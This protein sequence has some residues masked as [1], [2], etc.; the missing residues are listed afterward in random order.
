M[1]IESLGLRE[2]KRLAT[3]HAIQLA[4]LT[5]VEESGLEKVTVEQIS[6]RA[7]VSPRT[8]FN[9]FPTK[10]A[11]LVGDPPGLPGEAE[12]AAFV[13]AGAE[14]SI[15][16][17]LGRLV[18]RSAA[19]TEEKDIVN[20]RRRL[21]STYPHL[22]AMRMVALHELED[23]LTEVVARRLTEDDPD[24]A[25]DAAAL[26]SKARLIALVA[27]GTMRHAW[28][29]WAAAGGGVALARHVRDSFGELETLFAA[30]AAQ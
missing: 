25:G 20:L 13:H 24:L 1:S 30:P 22:F 9:Y 3:R 7:D 17:G 15:L 21:L 5:L 14:E 19:T 18:A 8:F 2:R 16:T 27:L 23:Q 10:E 4:C 26:R 11:A 28:S 29:K 12:Q 6:A